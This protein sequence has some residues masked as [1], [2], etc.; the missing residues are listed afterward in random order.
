LG[1]KHTEITESDQQKKQL[2]LSVKLNWCDSP[3][4]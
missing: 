1:N 3:W 2:S 4:R